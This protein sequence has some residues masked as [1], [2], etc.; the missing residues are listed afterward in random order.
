MCRNE[1]IL[2]SVCPGVWLGSGIGVH[3]VVVDR[4]GLSVGVGQEA[5]RAAD[6]VGCREVLGMHY[7]T[8]P[9][10]KIDQAAAK[11]AFADA[12]KALHLPAIGSQLE[13]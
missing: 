6:F 11:Q 12:G 13:L 7:D 2:A 5:F 9:P 1:L 8:F 4:P 10:I 3:G